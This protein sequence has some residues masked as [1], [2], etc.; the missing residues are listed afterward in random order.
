MVVVV[1]GAA[2]V[3]VVVAGRD[4]VVV[5]VVVAGGVV[6]DGGGCG[7]VELVVAGSSKVEAISSLGSGS[8]RTTRGAEVVVFAVVSVAAAA[9]VSSVVGMTTDGGIT[10]LRTWAM[11]PNEKPTAIAAA[12]SQ[13]IR[14]LV[15]LLMLNSLMARVSCL[16]Q[17]G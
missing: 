11:A 4:V 5:G 7:L 1:A 16:S 8:T 13:P 14:N 2:V 12:N 10:R 17:K 3:V 15:E 6:W 9:S